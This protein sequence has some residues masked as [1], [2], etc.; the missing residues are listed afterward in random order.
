MTMADMD[1]YADAHRANAERQ[2]AVQGTAM[3]MQN[4]LLAAHACGL[5]ASIMCAPLFCP[6]TVQAC[7]ELPPDW[8]PQGLIILGWPNAGGKPFKRLPLADVLRVID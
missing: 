7:L 3:A 5:G 6:G 2:M 4:L 1:R 8:E